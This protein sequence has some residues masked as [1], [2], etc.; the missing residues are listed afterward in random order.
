MPKSLSKLGLSANH[1]MLQNTIQVSFP[2]TVNER[3]TYLANF[4]HPTTFNRYLFCIFALTFRFFG[5]NEAPHTCCSHFDYIN[6]V[7][8]KRW[9]HE[10]KGIIIPRF[11]DEQTEAQ[12][13]R[14]LLQVTQFVS[15][16]ATRLVTLPDSPWMHCCEIQ[17]RWSAHA[18]TV[19]CKQ[20]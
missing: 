1:E 3:M 6:S 10:V 2:F 5:T 18:G 15:D 20:K 19:P 14:S 13:V 7:Y 9:C 11:M 12:R 16:T 8:P 17:S 4:E